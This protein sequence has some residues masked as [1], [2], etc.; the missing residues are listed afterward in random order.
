M[1]LKQLTNS[2][3]ILTS[4]KIGKVLANESYDAGID[5]GG[6]IVKEKLF[7]FGSFNPTVNRTL[8]LA[9][10]NAGLFSLGEHVQRY[11]T[12][13][14]AGKIDWNITNNHTFAFSIF[15]DPTKTNKSSFSSLNIDNTT[16]F[17]QLDYGSRNLSF[18]YNGALS[19]SWTL[20]SSFSINDNKFDEFGFDDFNLITDSTGP[21]SGCP[22]TC[23]GTFTAIG[24]GFI[25]PT[26]G[27]TYGFSAD[28][29]KTFS[30]LGQH[31]VGVGYA[32]QRSLYSGNRDRSGPKYTIPAT[33]AD[34]ISLATRFP[35]TAPAIGQTLNAQFSIESCIKY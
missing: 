4:N 29:V 33:N 23:R 34:G 21:Q 16:A 5:F 20:S 25:E 3:M 32:F 22:T 28:T 14:Y 8:V 12:L 15:G 35:A 27:K 7:F 1:L 24:R 31:S 19:S 17:S 13:N 10:S 11:R 30:L 6:P 9:A 18:R 26:Q 2:V